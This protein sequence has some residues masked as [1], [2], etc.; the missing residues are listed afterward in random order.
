MTFISYA[1]NYEDVMILRA[2]HKVRN[3]FYI[4]VGA[5][6]PTVHSVTKAFYERGWRGINIEPATDWFT[7]LQTQRPHDINIQVAVSESEGTL[8]FYNIKD[9]GLSTTNEEYA[10][11]HAESGFQVDEEEVPCTTLDN[12]CEKNQVGTVHFLKIDCEGSE[13][14]V[15]MGLS[16]VKYRPWIILVES[17][18][19]LSDK[20]TYR[21][22][23][24]LL[25]GRGYHF[26]YDDGLNRFY[27]ADEKK[28]LD[29]AFSHPPNVF[30]D[31]LKAS[32]YELR[33]E[34]QAN[35][36][37]V[38]ERDQWRSTAEYLREENERREAALVEHRRQLEEAGTRE[39]SERLSLQKTIEYLRGENERRERALTGQRQSLEALA[40]TLEMSEQAVRA[41]DARLVDVMGSLESCQHDLLR[42]E[43]DMHALQAEIVRR[44]EDVAAHLREVE[45]LHEVIHSIYGSTSWRISSPLRGAKRI[46]QARG[47]VI[48]AGA[49]QLLRWPARLLRPIFRKVV[50]WGWLRA[51]VVGV[52]GKDSALVRHSRLFLFGLPPVEET[53]AEPVDHV[54]ADQLNRQATRV[55]RQIHAALQ[56]RKSGKNR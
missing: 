40:K 29:K 54:Q 10:R 38:S 48:A 51:K 53:S 32:E 52:V 21:T 4:D 27:V 50:Q 56:A 26:V 18:E 35:R 20:P 24:A 2:L 22:W 3:G 33:I 6:D 45:R 14:S 7:R 8:R 31:F 49:Y 30:D 23:E 9:T 46:A 12:I 5:Q 47:R 44:N 17:T 16:L 41:S 28:N 15:L 39:S 43:A 13:K 11:R 37:A 36:L 19:P 55:Y 42:R 34:S 1:Q 25:V